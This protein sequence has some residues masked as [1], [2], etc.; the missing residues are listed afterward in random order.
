MSAKAMTGKKFG[1]LLVLSRAGRTVGRLATY[2]CKC[3]CGT[4]KV[5]SGDSL[6]R[7]STRSCGCLMRKA[8]GERLKAANTR[9]GMTR[10][11]TYRIWS[12]MKGR[13]SNVNLPKYPIY[14]GRG[15]TVCERWRKFQNFLS[16]MGQCP[17]GYTIERINNDGNYEPGNCKWIPAAQQAKNRRN[18]RVLTLNGE[19]M[20]LREWATKIGMNEDTLG[21]RLLRGWP[22]EK[23]ITQP[24]R[25][26]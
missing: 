2:W 21:M 5:I 4:E 9:H 7:G 17:V 11:K 6:R 16:D 19:T 3:D 10:T 15:I 18:N 20:I 25:R 12:Q 14:G 26:W 22:V 1:R 8:S 13:C 23:A 24:L